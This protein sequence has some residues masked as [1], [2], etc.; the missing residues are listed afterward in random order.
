M[1]AYNKVEYN[2]NTLID[3]TGTTAIA[4]D[5]FPGKTFVGADGVQTTGALAPIEKI[6]DLW[7]GSFTLADTTYGSWTASTTAK[8]IMATATLG[9]FSADM[10]NYLYVIK[11]KYRFDAIYTEGATLKAIPKRQCMESWQVLYR[12]FSTLTQL[13]AGTRPAYNAVA[14]QFTAPALEYYNTSGTD[15]LYISS[16]YGIYMAVQ[17]ATFSSTSSNSP[18]VT[19]KRPTINAR[20]NSSYFATGRKAE[21]DTTSPFSI[22]AELWRVKLSSTIQDAYDGVQAVF[23]NG[24]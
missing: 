9:T 5:V 6:R 19:Y 10:K 16:T 21:I 17:A 24:I 3:L 11:W 20:C 15:T 2:G 4:D 1:T 8:S 14:T 23:N 12:R 13:R 18:T 7:S 22:K